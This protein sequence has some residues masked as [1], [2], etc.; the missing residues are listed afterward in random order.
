M[1]KNLFEKQS[2]L[3]KRESESINTNLI[4][5]CAIF[6]FLLFTLLFS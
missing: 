2:N 1:M 6:A 3:Y 4:V 5:G